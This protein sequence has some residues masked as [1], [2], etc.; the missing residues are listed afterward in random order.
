M[1]TGPV[2][3]V[4]HIVGTVAGVGV[5]AVPAVVLIAYGATMLG[6]LILIAA[7]VLLLSNLAKL[8]SRAD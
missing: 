2:T 3:P 1:P 8:P 7:A 5:L 4:A 6:V